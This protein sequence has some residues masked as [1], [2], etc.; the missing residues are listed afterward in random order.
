MLIMSIDTQSDGRE[1]KVKGASPTEN[2]QV[3]CSDEEDIS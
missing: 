2:L 3:S 1:R